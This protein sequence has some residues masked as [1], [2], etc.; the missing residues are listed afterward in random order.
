MGKCAAKVR[1]L[2]EAIADDAW[3]AP[4]LL[5]EQARELWACIWDESSTGVVGST[6]VAPATIRALRDE[7]TNSDCWWIWTRKGAPMWMPLK[8]AAAKLRTEPVAMDDAAALAEL[9]RLHDGLSGDARRAVE[10]AIAKFGL[11]EKE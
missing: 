4:P 3:C 11:V 2:I 8:V 1:E 7:A 6:Y 10:W 5:P 9:D